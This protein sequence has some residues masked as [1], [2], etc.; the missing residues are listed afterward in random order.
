MN[1]EA[2]RMNKNYKKCPYC[3]FCNPKNVKRCIKC[4]K[5]FEGKKMI[6]DCLFKNKNSFGRISFSILFGY[7]KKLQKNPQ[8]KPSTEESKEITKIIFLIIFVVI[9][10]IIFTNIIS[11][12]NQ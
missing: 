6:I 5:K 4:G 2:G 11:N 12:F 10:F 9:S 3:D 1:K 7:F 8:Y